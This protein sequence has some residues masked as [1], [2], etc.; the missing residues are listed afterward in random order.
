MSA[1]VDV[2][3][4]VALLCATGLVLLASLGL[5]RFDDVFSRVHAATKASTLGVV[6]VALGTALQMEQA[7]DVAKL[8]LAAL[9]Q[10]I[11]APVSGH[12]VSRAAYWSGGE[13]SPDTDVDDLAAV[14]LEP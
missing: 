1:V 10:L 3:S 4:A 9:L 13:L 7:G 11:S 5:H 6:L 14:E 2:V 12:M 8:L